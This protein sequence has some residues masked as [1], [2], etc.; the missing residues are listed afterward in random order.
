MA[1]DDA[2]LLPRVRAFLGKILAAQGGAVGPFT[3]GGG[4]WFGFDGECASCSGQVEDGGWGRCRK[5]S[6][7]VRM[8]L[9]AYDLG[10]NP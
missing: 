9:E 1:G 7:A 8:A 2:E 6:Q 3:F 4:P 5:C 10:E